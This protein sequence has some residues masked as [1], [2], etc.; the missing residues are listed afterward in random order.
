MTKQSASKDTNGE[1]GQVTIQV[2]VFASNANGEPDVFFTSITCGQDEIDDGSHYDIAKEVAE[3]HGYS[4]SLAMDENDP[5]WAMLKVPDQAPAQSMQRVLVQGDVDDE[6]LSVFLPASLDLKSA[7]ALV[8]LAIVRANLATAQGSKG[9]YFAALKVELAEHGI[10]CEQRPQTLVTKHQWDDL[11]MEELGNL[12]TAGREHEFTR[13]DIINIDDV[14]EHGEADRLECTPTEGGGT[15]LLDQQHISQLHIEK[16]VV[17]YPRSD[18]YG[19]P[20][21]ATDSGARKYLRSLGFRVDNSLDVES[22]ES[23]D[24][25]PV[26]FSLTVNAP[27]ELLVPMDDDSN[28][29]SD[30]GSADSPN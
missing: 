26:H 11:C 22:D 10:V 28:L 2:A 13:V 6:P 27:T 15:L 24:D 16:F 20:E 17:T 9:D 5:G 4:P 14:F 19:V 25:S 18:R 29:D 3:S 21:C 12:I 1:P 7:A 8:D 30:S 23:G